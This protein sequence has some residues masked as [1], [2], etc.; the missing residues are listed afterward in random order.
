MAKKK[1]KKKKKKKKKTHKNKKKKKG[2][3][4][5]LK[6]P[7]FFFLKNVWLSD[8]FIDNA[9]KLANEK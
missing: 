2:F 3:A 8:G 6:L 1:T 5:L 4:Y 7:H 9:L